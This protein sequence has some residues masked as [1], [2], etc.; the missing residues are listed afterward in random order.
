[1]SAF[2][3]TDCTMWIGGLALTT[4][5][6]ELSVKET[7]DDQETTTF[8]NGG[9]KSRIGGL[10]TV[11][12]D[13]KGNWE[14]PVDAAGITNLG[15]ADQ[16]VT[17]S[18]LGTEGSPAKFFQGGVFDYERLG[19][20]GEVDPFSMSI[21]GTNGVGVVTGQ[22]AKAKGNV[23]A[24][25]AVGSGLTDLSANDQVGASQFLYAVVHVFT[26]GTTMTLKVQSDDNAGFSSPTDRITLSAIT[27]TG[28]T[29]VTR[30]A[31]PITD[32]YFRF[33]CTAITGTF[34]IGAAI[35]IA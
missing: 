5:S 15:V 27:A 10:K 34:N 1:M 24:T 30:L 19:K 16:V 21:M 3:L 8:G 26:A 12:G 28:G 6:N 11:D 31:G 18:L 14:S 2:V 13:A 25:G 23:S 29:W 9:Y 35:G 7:V 32:T 20:V 17:G 33:N 22:I 4:Y